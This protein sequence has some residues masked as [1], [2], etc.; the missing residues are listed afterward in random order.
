[1]SHRNKEDREGGEDSGFFFGNKSLDCK[2]YRSNRVAFTDSVSFSRP[3]ELVR[4]YLEGWR[5]SE[6]GV[7][8]M[9][10]WGTKTN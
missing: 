4:E 5:Q 2:W 7:R 8:T 10:I 3:L 1:M 6:R 9:Y